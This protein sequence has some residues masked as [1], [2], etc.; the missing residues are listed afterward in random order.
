LTPEE[1]DAAFEVWPDNWAAVQVF[2]ALSTQWRAG[3]TGPIGL[4]YTAVPV[5]LRLTSTPRADWPDVFDCVRVMEVAA[6]KT[7]REN[8]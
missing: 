1:A 8:K 6:I 4:D 7:M 3:A 2:S 5:V